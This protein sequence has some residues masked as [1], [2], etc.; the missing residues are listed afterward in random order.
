MRLTLVFIRHHEVNGRLYHHGSELPP[1]ALPQETV[2]QLLDQGV[3]CE[4]PERRSLYRLFA[5]FSDTKE[6]EA[7]TKE[8]LTVYALSQ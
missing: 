8:E 5:P 1:G 6:T 7:F 3:L 4:C 2:N